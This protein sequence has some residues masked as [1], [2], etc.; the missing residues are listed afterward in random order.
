LGGDQ[1]TGDLL[2]A[3]PKAHPSS[4]RTPDP[5]RAVPDPHGIVERVLSLGEAA[6]LGVSRTQLEA[7]I[8]AGQ[9]EPLPTG[10]TRMVPTREVERIAGRST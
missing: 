4:V 2:E 8:D 5:P 9:I 6:R 1:T 3:P 10:F 7:M